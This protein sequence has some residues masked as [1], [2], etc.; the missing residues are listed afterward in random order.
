MLTTIKSVI[1]FFMKVIFIDFQL[2][3]AF[4]FHHDVGFKKK[5]KKWLARAS[6]SQTTLIDMYVEFAC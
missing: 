6:I 5:K 4:Q 2:I 3:A 1:T